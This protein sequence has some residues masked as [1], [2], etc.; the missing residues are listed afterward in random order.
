MALF[1]RHAA[2]V[3]VAVSW[4][5][6][7][8]IEHQDWVERRSQARPLADDV[9]QDVRNERQEKEVYYETVT[10]YET[11]TDSD[12]NTTTVPMK[13]KERR[14]RMVWVY[15]H[16]EWCP[17]RT[18]EA[19]GDSHADVDWPQ[20]TLEDRERPG[21]QHETYTAVFE[22]AR[23]GK[24]AKTREA[25]LDEETWRSLAMGASYHLDL[26]VFGGIKGVTP[27]Q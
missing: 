9:E 26:G 8:D 5:R 6:S 11:T 15:D 16:L 24:N 19:S 1:R 17:S 25:E 12:G 21:E 3:L 22:T 13:H 18:V 7:I 23:E 27:A 14:T 10:E 2:A 20:Y 4:Q